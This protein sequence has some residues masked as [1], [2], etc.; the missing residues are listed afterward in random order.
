MRKDITNYLFKICK[1]F[2]L[3]L[4]YIP[5]DRQGYDSYLIH[6]RGKSVAN[7]STTAFYS[8][9]KEAR[10]K[11]F[12]GRLKRGL[13]KVMDDSSAQNQVNIP[14]RMGKILIR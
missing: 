11:D 13:M 10:D 3:S 2:K 8:I 1:R 5:D 4:T 9:P 7:I 12:M 6:Y 14:W